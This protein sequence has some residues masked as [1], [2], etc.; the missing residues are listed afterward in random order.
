MSSSESGNDDLLTQ[1]GRC[2]PRSTKALVRA[3]PEAR[4]APRTADSPFWATPPC[5]QH[6]SRNTS[7]SSQICHTHSEDG[8]IRCNYEKEPKK[9]NLSSKPKQ[10]QCKVPCT[11]SP[12]GFSGQLP[13]LVSRAFL[14]VKPLCPPEGVT[15]RRSTSAPALPLLI[16]NPRP[17]SISPSFR[18][19]LQKTS[20]TNF[21]I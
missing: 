6:L 21:T 14:G 17:R 8:G 18:P 2:P 7:P 5:P 3:T 13:A 10:K 15:T 11:S 1:K 19:R 9:K 12:R 4:C 20:L 16:Y